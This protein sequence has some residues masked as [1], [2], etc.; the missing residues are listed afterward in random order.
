VLFGT[1]TP[2]LHRRLHQPTCHQRLVYWQVASSPHFPLARYTQDEDSE[3]AVLDDEGNPVPGL[4]ICHSTEV[5]PG[6][7]PV[8]EKGAFEG[9]GGDDDEAQEVENS[10]AG[11]S[12]FNY[13]EMP[14]SSKTEMK[15]WIKGYVNS[16]RQNLKVR[17]RL[18]SR[19]CLRSCP[20]LRSFAHVGW[21][22]V[23]FG[24]IL[25]PAGNPASSLI[26]TSNPPLPQD[27]ESIEQAQVKAF[28]G[29]AK[30]FAPWLLKK[31]KVGS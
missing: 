7:L 2:W 13:T 18:W 11:N 29:E 28:M 1:L 17:S 3:E 20:R 14:F 31:Y 8:Q 12:A 4:F 24:L 16:V 15:E 5:L 30:Q 19:S 9:E 27:D 10:I 26:C 25:P 21:P 23:G 22:R 6:G